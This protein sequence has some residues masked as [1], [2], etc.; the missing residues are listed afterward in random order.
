MQ[1]WSNG[2]VG[3]NGISYYAMNQW[4]VAALQPP[5]LAAMCVWEGA[6]DFYRDFSHHGGI[7]LLF[8]RD[9]VPRHGRS[10][11]STAEG[12][13]DFRSRINGEWCS[14]PETLPEEELGANR[15]DFYED[16]LASTR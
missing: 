16:C 6:A 10:R 14:G 2:K 7:L 4:Q 3:L 15:S 5:H 8:G 11:A 12:T 9:L 1:P 13:R